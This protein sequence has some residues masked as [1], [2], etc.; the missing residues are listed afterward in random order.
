MYIHLLVFVLCGCLSCDSLFCLFPSLVLPLS[1]PFSPSLDSSNS[2]SLGEANSRLSYYNGVIQLV[3][4][5][6]SRYNNQG[7]VL[8]STLISFLCDP[9]AGAGTPEF[10]VRTSNPSAMAAFK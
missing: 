6:G 9:D 3:Y 4:R 2:W 1:H 7:H 10:Q 5:N 8:R